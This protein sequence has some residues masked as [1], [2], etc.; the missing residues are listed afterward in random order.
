MIFS[1]VKC[2]VMDI[3]VI[4]LLVAVVAFAY[5]TEVNKDDD[6][7]AAIACGCFNVNR[8]VLHDFVLFPKMVDQ[9]RDTSF[10]SIAMPVIIFVCFGI[11]QWL[12]GVNIFYEADHRPVGIGKMYKA[13]IMSEYIQLCPKNVILIVEIRIVP[14]QCYC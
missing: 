7:L 1:R 6:G 11:F 14:A 3:K 2:S 5:Q 10:C 9:V 13:I 12:A 4:F 8:S